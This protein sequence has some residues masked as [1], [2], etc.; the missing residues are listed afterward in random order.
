MLGL[1][2]KEDKLHMKG[3]ISA[4]LEVILRDDEGRKQLR[5]SL[6]T[7]RDCKISVGER[8]YRISTKNTAYRSSRTGSVVAK[9][10]TGSPTAKRK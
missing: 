4:D 7:G 6:I 2:H 1:G 9:N 3:K 10:V 8:N 5:R